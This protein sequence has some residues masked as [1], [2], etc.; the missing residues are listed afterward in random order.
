MTDKEFDAAIKLFE[1]AQD[2]AMKLSTYQLWAEEAEAISEQL[3][4]LIERMKQA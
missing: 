1:K 2:A 3:A 4:M